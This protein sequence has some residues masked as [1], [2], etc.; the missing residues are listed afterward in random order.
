M[1]AAHLAAERLLEQVDIL[2]GRRD[3][4]RVQA[5][6]HVA[7]LV[8]LQRRLAHRDD[9]PGQLQLGDGDARDRY[10]QLGLVA[11]DDLDPVDEALGRK[12]AL[13]RTVE[14]FSSKDAAPTDWAMHRP[15]FCARRA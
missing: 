11:G 14:I 2:A 15:G 8:P 10:F 5:V 7:G 12:D 1:V 13:G 3:P 4:V 6:H 9:R